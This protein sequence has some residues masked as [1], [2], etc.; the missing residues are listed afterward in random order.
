MKNIALGIDI[1]GSHI[2]CRIFDTEKNRF[3]DAQ[4]LRKPVD[5]HASAENIL[6]AWAE[7]IQEK[8]NQTNITQVKG[9]GFA[10]PGPFDYEQGIGLFQ[11]VPKFENLYGV[12]VRNEM[13][14]RLNLPSDFPVLF[15]NDA[16]CFAI[17]ESIQGE[18]ASHDKVLAITLGTGF[19]TTFI[20]NHHPVAGISGIPEDGFLY[21]IPLV[22]GIADDYFSTRWFEKT[23]LETTG[24]T[25]VGVKELASKA[26]EDKRVMAIFEIFGTQLGDFLASYIT[27]FEA[28]GLVMGGNIS[29]AYPLFESTLK[30]AFAHHGTS[31]EIY[32]S[33]LGEDAALS[34]SA[35][36]CNH[37]S[38]NI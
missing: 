19:G 33:K 20:Q 8:L 11:G 1:G 17:G 2:S 34:G 30:K 18:I 23:Y 25:I 31:V 6:N 24:Q 10:M 3:A 12:N 37:E 16:S 21:H 9:I 27:N 28:T 5:C 38:K 26:A 14:Q 22:H 35:Y 15:M 32:V 13:R 4:A 7:A 36:L 29:G